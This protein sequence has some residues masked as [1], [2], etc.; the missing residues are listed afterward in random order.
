MIWS[1]LAPPTKG[2]TVSTSICASSILLSNSTSCCWYFRCASTMSKLFAA[3]NTSSRWR[4][5]LICSCASFDELLATLNATITAITLIIGLNSVAHWINSSVIAL[6]LSN[7]PLT[8]LSKSES[9]RWVLL[10]ISYSLSAF[11]LAC[12]ADIRP[13]SGNI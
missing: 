11:V 8:S 7:T 10:K 12:A 2:Y 6:H 3:T 1:I 9:I 13:L 5:A 4:I